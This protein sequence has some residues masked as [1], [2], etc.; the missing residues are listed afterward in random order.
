MEISIWL[1]KFTF[2]IKMNIFVWNY[3]KIQIQNFYHRLKVNYFF[4]FFET[5]PDILSGVGVPT[6]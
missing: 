4:I 6:L 1:I 3:P 2:S 5:F